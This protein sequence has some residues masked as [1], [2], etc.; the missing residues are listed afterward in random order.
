MTEECLKISNKSY[1]L[2]PNTIGGKITN[3]LNADQ[4]YNMFIELN[5]KTKNIQASMVELITRC[6]YYNGLLINESV[7]TQHGYEKIFC[8]ETISTLTYYFWNNKILK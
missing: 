1:L 4:D 5:I 7:I 8:N 6:V 2:L 3:F